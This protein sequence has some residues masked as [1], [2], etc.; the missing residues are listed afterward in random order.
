MR[1]RILIFGTGAGGQHAFK[2][3]DSNHKI[4]GFLD[5]NATK[6]GAKFNTIPVYDPQILPSLQF[7]RI[8]IASDYYKD[9]LSQLTNELNIDENVIDIFHSAAHKAPK[10]TTRLKIWLQQLIFENICSS[11]QLISVCLLW[12]NKDIKK[13]FDVKNINWLDKIEKDVICTFRDNAEMTVHSPA[14]VDKDKHRKVIKLPAVRAYHFHNGGISTNSNSIQIDN[15]IIISRVPSTNIVTSDYSSGH[16]AF[17]GQK[18]GLIKKSKL[19]AISKGVAITGSSDTNY[20]HW[21]LE[22]LSKTQY[23]NHLPSEYKDFPILISEQAQKIESI[24]VFLNHIET[25]RN[26]IYLSSTEV[27]Q[28]SNLIFISSPNYLVP[29]LKGRMSFSMSDNYTRLGSILYLRDI[30]EKIAKAHAKSEKTP[31]R[32]FLARKP[33]IR[34]YN[35]NQVESLLNQYNFKSI[36]LEDLTL[37]E[38]VTLISQAEYIVGPTGAAWTNLIFA[39]KGV[40]ALCWMAEEYGDLTCFST[41]AEQLEIDLVF[42]T[43]KN[44][45]KSTRETYYHPYSVDITKIQS[46]LLDQVK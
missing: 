25:T 22:V 41:I 29:N 26:I 33:Y 34:R 35:Q 31:K 2:M 8:V 13:N 19:K 39:Q 9:I 17:H 36:Y 40:K 15:K 10:L 42:L 18:R 16:L 30:G 14:F 37:S 24:R 12:L 38:Q 20:Y 6:H 44:N 28:V 1:S 11:N 27:Y 3:F 46:W 5:N 4:I 45:A 32:V 7:E 21:L 23:I 43:Y